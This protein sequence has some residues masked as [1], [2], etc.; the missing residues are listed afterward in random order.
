[1]G[2]NEATAL[3]AVVI[4]GLVARGF[5]P[6]VFTHQKD[7]ILSYLSKGVAVLVASQVLRLVYWDWVHSA[8][9]RYYPELWETW[10]AM[11]RQLA[12]NVVPNLMLVC[13]GYYF[14]KARWL[15]IPDEDRDKW[16]ILSAPFY[17]ARHVVSITLS[18]I[19]RNR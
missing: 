17:P 8:G 18:K 19:R 1:M 9:L 7:D 14:L 4:M 13:A 15:L 6:L 12:V 11:S 3:F 5:I 16:S 10:L 2:L